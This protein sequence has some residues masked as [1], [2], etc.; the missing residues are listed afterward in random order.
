MRTHRITPGW[1][2][3]LVAVMGCQAGGPK[4][5][6]SEKGVQMARAPLADVLA[7]HTP[8]LLKIEGVNGTGEGE[9]SG[10]PVFVV[11]VTSDTPELRARLPVA[12]EGYRVVVRVA[13]TVRAEGH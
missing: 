9:E 5:A 11:F 6:A 13:G 12:V 4:T 2:L 7:L 3:L 10:E 8:E 1:I